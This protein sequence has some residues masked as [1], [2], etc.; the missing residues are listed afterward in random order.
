MPKYLFIEQL[1]HAFTDK[2]LVMYNA[3]RKSVKRSQKSE[4]EQ[5]SFNVCSS[6]NLVPLPLTSPCILE[7]FCIQEIYTP[8]LLYIFF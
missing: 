1:I 4:S 6:V 7:K 8:S 3:Q 5:E 2:H